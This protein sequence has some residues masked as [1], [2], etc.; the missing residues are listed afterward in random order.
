MA[1]RL[2]LLQADKYPYNKVEGDIY[3]VPYFILVTDLPECLLKR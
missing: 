1:I 3:W 2:Q